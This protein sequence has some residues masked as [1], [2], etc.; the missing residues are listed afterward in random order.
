MQTLMP[1][2]F[3]AGIPP[4]SG[5]PIPGLYRRFTDL[6]QCIGLVI[7]CAYWATL[8][9]CPSRTVDVTREN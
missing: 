4:A 8:S 2:P 3:H 1:P 6:S 9:S 5:S 7:F